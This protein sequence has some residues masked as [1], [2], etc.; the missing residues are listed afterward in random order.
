MVFDVQPVVIQNFLQEGG[1]PSVLS[2]GCK[3]QPVDEGALASTF[4]IS[5]PEGTFYLKFHEVEGAR[6]AAFLKHLIPLNDL[7]VRK[8]A[9]KRRHFVRKMLDS[10]IEQRSTLIPKPCYFDLSSQPMAMQKLRREKEKVVAELRMEGENYPAQLNGMVGTLWKE[11]DIQH[12]PTLSLE[13]KDVWNPLDYSLENVSCCTATIGEF[14]TKAEWFLKD[15]IQSKV[16]AGKGSIEQI[17]EKIQNK[18]QHEQRD[19]KGYDSLVNEFLSSLELKISS[20][21]LATDLQVFGQK[22]LNRVQ[23]RLSQNQVSSIAEFQNCFL[24]D[25]SFPSEYASCPFQKLLFVAERERWWTSSKRTEGKTIDQLQQAEIIA[26]EL[27]QDPKRFLSIIE[28][29]LKFKATYEKLKQMPQAIVPQDA[30]PFN[31]FINQADGNTTMLDLEDVSMGVRF[32]DLSTVYVFKILRGLIYQKITKFQA[33]EYLQAA[34]N[35]YNSTVSFPLSP[36]ELKLMADYSMAVFLNFLPQFG[37]ILRMDPK[38]LDA[39]NLGMS[40]DAFVQQ[41]QLLK[42]ISQLWSEIYPFPPESYPQEN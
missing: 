14:Q 36:Q 5:S 4:K 20:T 21:D 12:I 15:K 13:K 33:I 32:A 3:I 29:V 24:A 7:E 19:L 42:R 39:Y 23:E 40:L 22:I 26:Q 9:E 27:V 17:Q 10:V 16:Q 25:I 11:L 8:H 38:E 30:H 41:F 1:M 18:L 31:F 6:G 34:I 37:I 28:D 2:Q 35:G